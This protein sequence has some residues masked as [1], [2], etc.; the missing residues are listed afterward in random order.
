MY[1][2]FKDIEHP[3]KNGVYTIVDTS[4]EA[5]Q[6]QVDAEALGI[7]DN[8]LVQ[9]TQMAAAAHSQTG[10]KLSSRFMEWIN[11]ND[12]FKDK[13]LKEKNLLLD[14]LYQGIL[15]QYIESGNK[16]I[17][18]QGGWYRFTDEADV[19]LGYRIDSNVQVNSITA[20]IDYYCYILRERF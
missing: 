18:Y 10:L 4:T 8:E 3:I 1:N 7:T 12:N 17:Y 16:Y 9:L 5:D 20:I 14:K 15:K 11:N 6:G 13:T 2:S 19:A